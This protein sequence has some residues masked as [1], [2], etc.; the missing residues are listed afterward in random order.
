MKS[1]KKQ[2]TVY[3]VQ[4]A[5]LT[6][7]SI[8]FA[9]TPLGYLKIT[10]A[11]GATLSHIPVIIAAIVLGK[12]A[13]I[14]MGSLFGLLSFITFTFIYPADLMAPAFTPFAENA[15]MGKNWLSLIIV[16]VP[17]I[18]LGYLTW[19]IYSLFT[20]ASK[21][22]NR[23]IWATLAALIG[24]FLHSLMV[25]SLIYFIFGSVYSDGQKYV[26]FII[27]W[28]GVN[29]LCEMLVAAL[30]SA[31]LVIPLQKVLSSTRV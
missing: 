13:G 11:I 22:R 28:A 24:T 16:F 21:N 1:T 26:N 30:I 8:I 17:R 27:A 6:A 23:P 20:K 3:F 15:I 2:N 25:L 10:P 4:L 12:W 9:F 7:I 29:C 5:I 18:L 19:L 31:A 14:Y